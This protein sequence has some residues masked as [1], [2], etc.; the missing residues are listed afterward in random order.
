MYVMESVD[1]STL[2][3]RPG[4]WQSSGQGVRL[5]HQGLGLGVYGSQGIVSYFISGYV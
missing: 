1:G 3:I 4:F 5:S 2:W